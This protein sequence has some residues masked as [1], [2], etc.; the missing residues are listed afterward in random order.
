MK[1][2]PRAVKKANIVKSL[3]S[4][5]TTGD[6]PSKPKTVTIKSNNTDKTTTST[7]KTAVPKADKAVKKSSTAIPANK[8]KPRKLTAK[9]IE[10]IIRDLTNKGRKKGFVTDAEIME[11]FPAKPSPKALNALY[12]FLADKNIEIVDT[13][14]QPELASQPI[15]TG[16][17]ESRQGEKM[18]GTRRKRTEDAKEAT[19]SFIEADEAELKADFEVDEADEADEVDEVDEVDET[20]IDEV[21]DSKETD[22]YDDDDIEDDVGDI[23]KIKHQPSYVAVEWEDDDDDLASVKDDDVDLS[24]DNDEDQADLPKGAVSEQ[25]SDD[26]VRMYL[27]EMGSIQLLTREG[28]VEIAKMIEKGQHEM[29]DILLRS[30]LIVNYLFD[31]GKKLRNGKARARDIVSG[32][33]DD[34][35]VIEEESQAAEQ[36]MKKLRVAKKYFDDRNQFKEKIGDIKD[37]KKRRECEIELEET[38]FLL[39]KM[40]R[41]I[42][43]NTKQIDTMFQVMLH[44]NDKIDLTFTQLSRY[45][46]DLRAPVSQVATIVDQWVEDDPAKC[47]EIEER[48]KRETKHGFRVARRILEK[49]QAGA[50][51]IDKMIA[52]TDVKLDKFRSE[53]KRL[54]LAERKVSE[55]KSLLVEANLRLVISI[56][57]KYTNRGL[58]F[59]DLIQEGN[60]GLMKAVDKFEYRRGYKFSTYATWWIRQAITRAIADQ[61]RTI[62]IPV[63]MIE[64]INKLIRTS[65]HLVQE[66]GREPSPEEIS[67]KMDLPV[68]KVRKVLKIAK[69]PISLE[70]PIG[71]EDDSHLGDFIP[72]ASAVLPS[73]S[74]V[75]T[76]LS[77]VTR[78]VLGTLTPREEKV[79]K[80]RFGIDEKKDHTLEEVGQDFDVT[81]E[82]IRQIEAKALRK[83]RHPTRSRMLRSF[84]E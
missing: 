69:E 1:K 12:D 31:L 76:Y 7:G 18:T 72:D 29:L 17:P 67:A 15:E 28:E 3:K 47:E 25:T 38:R 49:V 62:R 39:L 24:D 56:A 53:I 43:F 61:A 50:R 9:G 45:Q 13:I 63:H 19:D 71:D 68:E 80:M 78:R 54:K 70:T 22:D 65:R 30:E 36:V 74:V 21:G 35:Q 23:I 44:H 48:I 58:Q 40:L 46:R 64:T 4:T 8:S 59:L 42:N 60:I 5:P 2:H 79:L 10:K 75:N 83:L 84:Y 41:S 16:K 82:R 66:F 51:R 52:Q 77:D 32:I 26:P 27:R 6:T 14:K 37:M 20:E 33:D 55:A 81:R 57:K 34:D 11:I 73:E